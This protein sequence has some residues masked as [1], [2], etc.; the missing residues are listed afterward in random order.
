VRIQTYINGIAT[1]DPEFV[2]EFWVLVQRQVL[3]KEP[4]RSVH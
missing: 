1:I 4:I 3:M 2:E